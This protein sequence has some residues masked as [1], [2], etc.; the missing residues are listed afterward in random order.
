[1]KLELFNF[2][3]Y[4]G[5]RTIEIADV[6]LSLIVGESGKGKSSILNAISFVLYGGTGTRNIS[7]GETTCRVSLHLNE[8]IIERSCKPTHLTFSRGD[9]T[10]EDDAAQQ[11]INDFFGRH[12]ECISYIHQTVNKSFLSLGPSEKLE[13]LETVLFDRRDATMTPSEIKKKC[14]SELKVLT[15]EWDKLT[16][17]L[18]LLQTQLAELP[19][20]DVHVDET[21]D[22]KHLARRFMFLSN[23]QRLYNLY[24]Q[25]MSNVSTEILSLE[26][27][28]KQLVDI[29]E[30][31]NLTEEECKSLEKHIFALEQLAGF[32]WK[33]FLEY[34]PEECS[35]TLIEY[36]HDIQ[37]ARERQKLKKELR[38]LQYDAIAHE[39]LKREYK[40][41][42]ERPEAFFRCPS[43]EESLFLVNR[44]L[45]L[46]SGE[47]VDTETKRQLI[48]QMKAKLDKLDAVAALH[49]EMSIRLHS[50]TTIDE[51][52]EELEEQSKKWKEY[53]N[54][55]E[56]ISRLRP[57]IL[58]E[59]LSLSLAREKLKGAIETRKHLAR[60][61][62][63]QQRLST[64][65]SYSRDL[66][67]IEI[68]DSPKSELESTRRQLS[69]C[70]LRDKLIEERARTNKKRAEALEFQQR[71]NKIEKRR[72]AILDLKALVVRSE[73]DFIRDTLAS[74][75]IAVNR[76]AA[77][78]FVNEPLTVQITLATEGR[79]QLVIDIY[80]K[81][82]KCG[83]STLSGGEAARLNIC[84]TLALSQR[85]GG[86]L[87]LLD[88]CTS[89]LDVE[90]SELVFSLLKHHST[91]KTILV[92]HGVIEGIFDEVLTL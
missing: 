15:S 73:A 88:E 9:E 35:E 13:L 87:L 70:E 20:S 38:G 68:F 48:K 62:Q 72:K 40:E 59:E 56:L 8:M 47:I 7:D 16:G 90:S 6:G 21:V 83:F 33:N 3:C 42:E 51:P 80:Y 18:E 69:N 89:Q 64:L 30:N 34:T 52:I 50:F 53:K 25:K 41:L 67:S 31:N 55:S 10:Y 61:E 32:E 14:S 46:S 19:E 27:E 29:S 43:C 76:F 58:S 79:A 78:L 71:R 84:F 57:Y 74:I 4:R 85:F 22:T 2:R 65:Y 26:T 37:I 66:N 36:E 39:D 1:M 54:R 12:F 75:E 86:A 17:S 77:E 49:E 45:V 60:R 91:C 44:E 5:S 11:F 92:A 24:S 23:R 28:M 81:N 63:L 82:M